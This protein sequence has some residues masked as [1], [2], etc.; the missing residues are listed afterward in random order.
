ML[1]D[2]MS[3]SVIGLPPRRVHLCEVQVIWSYVTNSI[4]CE[5]V[6]FKLFTDLR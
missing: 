3:H 4:L 2:N 6:K 1:T 5:A